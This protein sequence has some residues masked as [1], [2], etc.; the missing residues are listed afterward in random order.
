M[1]KGFLVDSR[2]IVL[3]VACDSECRDFTCRT[4]TECF[5]TCYWCHE[6]GLSCQDI[7]H[8]LSLIL[9]YGHTR[10]ERHIYNGTAFCDVCERDMKDDYW[11]RMVPHSNS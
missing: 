10:Q 5:D 9:A 4:R 11:L 1:S 8:K 2:E 6:K 3:M 7:T